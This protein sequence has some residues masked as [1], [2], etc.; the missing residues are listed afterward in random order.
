MLR[1]GHI[2]FFFHYYFISFSLLPGNGSKEPEILQPYLEVLVDE[3]LSLTRK[4][5]FD[6]YKHYHYPNYSWI[7]AEETKELVRINLG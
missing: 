2:F 5:L 6:A 1:V 7:R 3:I 4:E